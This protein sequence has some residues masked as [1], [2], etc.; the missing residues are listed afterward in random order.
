[1]VIMLLFLPGAGNV[2]AIDPADEQNVLLDAFTLKPINHPEGAPPISIA[3]AVGPVKT[4]DTPGNNKD[5]NNIIA[6]Q[7]IVI[8]FILDSA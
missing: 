2:Y 8:I 5:N 6:V 4:E 1:M 3:T 7:I